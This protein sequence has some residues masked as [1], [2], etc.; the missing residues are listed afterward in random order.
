MINNNS[1]VAERIRQIEA[2]EN[3]N[4]DAEIEQEQTARKASKLF[5]DLKQAEYYPSATMGLQLPTT[6]ESLST[7][8]GQD[9]LSEENQ[10]KMFQSSL[11]VISSGNIQFAETITNRISA[12]FD[13]SV[14]ALMNESALEWKAEMKLQFKKTTST[15][16]VYLCFQKYLKDYSLKNETADANAYD[17]GS[18]ELLYCRWQTQQIIRQP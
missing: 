8:L 2:R 11:E 4:R 14:F 1:I 18:I 5:F 10:K 6:Y 15:D 9:Q 17:V 12:S 3:K 16:A 13:P 7:N